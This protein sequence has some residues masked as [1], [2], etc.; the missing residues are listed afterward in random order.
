MPSRSLTSVLDRT[1]G[2]VGAMAVQARS[3]A[4]ES[5]NPVGYIVAWIASVVIMVGSVAPW[6]TSGF[7]SLPGTQADGMY[8]LALGAIAAVVL[9]IKAANQSRWPLIVAVVTGILCGLIAVI[10][11]IRASSLISAED[12]QSGI[13]S[14][15]W[16]MWMTLVGAV[17]LVVGC[18]VADMVDSPRALTAGEARGIH[19]AGDDVPM[20]WDRATWALFIVAFAFGG[21]VAIVVGLDL[22]FGIVL[23]P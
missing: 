6:A 5:V 1:T 16:G 3:S 9:L 21:F 13:V 23:L 18:I 20:H 4:W 8:T 10:D 15:G 22:L 11:L 17:L 2:R 7:F 12:Q 14:I 19:S